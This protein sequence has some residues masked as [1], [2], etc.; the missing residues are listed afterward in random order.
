MR[1]WLAAALILCLM[2]L[3]ALGEKAPLS[4]AFDAF[5]TLMT[6]TENVTLT[7]KGEFEYD[8]EAFKKVDAAYIQAATDSFMDLI[9]YTASRDVWRESGYTVT[10]KDNVGYAIE[11]P[12]RRGYYEFTPNWKITPMSA[13]RYGTYF[14]L[15][16]AAVLL[17]EGL[18]APYITEE[19]G[20]VSLDLKAGDAPEGL[21]AFIRYLICRLAER[22]M[23]APAIGYMIE[24]APAPTV[25]IF[26]DDYS[27]CWEKEYEDQ[28]GTPVP[29]DFFEHL[30]MDDSEELT[31]AYNRVCDAL[32]EREK[33]LSEG[34][35]TGIVVIGGDFETEYYPTYGDY[36]IARG[37]EYVSFENNRSAMVAWRRQKTGE[38][39]T[40]PLL[41]AMEYSDNEDLRAK[42]W[43]LYDEMVQD[44]I[45][46]LREQGK[47]I[48]YVYDDGTLQG[49]MDP[50]E[51][52]YDTVAHLAL[53][54]MYKVRVGDVSLKIDLDSAGRITGAVGDVTLIF[55]N[56]S[57]VGHTVHFTF[58]AT[59]GDFGTSAVRIVEPFF[60][61][62][63]TELPSQIEIDGVTYWIDR[64]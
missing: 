40:A 45:A 14:E 51:L 21:G 24:E 7:F 36:L 42:Y 53:A 18:L 6:G 17:A 49:A 48:G 38:E 37:E 59:A 31:D 9:L 8:G 63:E 57:E 50:S 16:R 2:P 32:T 27:S 15:G 20:C 3:C 1:R 39:W 58:T 28:T 35:E 26:Y 25:E 41:T 61:D 29:G 10:A 34:H 22:Y 52:R 11:R 60:N 13:E 54:N 33:A 12:D 62:G 23:E 55:E 46:A 43:E 5:E 56:L 30:W 4:R 19:E 47:A 44:Y 64:K